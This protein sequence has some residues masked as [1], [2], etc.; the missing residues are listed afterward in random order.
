MSTIA[1]RLTVFIGVSL[2]V[3]AMF[4]CGGFDFNER[5]LTLTMWM[6]SCLWLGGWAAAYPFTK[7]QK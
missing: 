1:K 4:W 2:I 3:T 6:F 5:G 7:E